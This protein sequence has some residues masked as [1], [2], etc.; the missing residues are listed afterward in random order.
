LLIK[1][2][3]ERGMPGSEVQGVCGCG[4]GSRTE[5]LAVSWSTAFRLRQFARGS[6][7][8]LPLAGGLLGALLSSGAIL[9]DQSVHLPAYWIYSPSTAS[10]VLSAIVGAMAALTG[11]VVTVTVLVVQMATGTFSARYLR[12]W[13][14]DR[15]LKLLLAVLVGTLAFSFGLL[16]RIGTNFVPD[17]GVTAAG[18]LVVV[19][20]LL[21]VVF[22]DRFLHRLRPVAVAA[23][24][25]HYVHR[26]FARYA[27]ALAAPDVFSGLFDPA[28]EQPA[29]VVRGA[30]PGAIQAVDARGLARWAREHQCLVVLCHRVGDFVPAGAR[31]IET[32]GGAASGSRAEG[33]L[34]KM[35]VLGAERTI[36]QDPAF[37]IRIMVDIAD[38]ALSPAVNDPTTAV[39]ALDHLSDV[40]RRIGATDLSRSQWAAAGG[41]VRTGLV[42]PARSWEDYLMLGVTEIREYGCTAIQV[43]R[44]MRAMLEELRDE[45]RPEHRPAVEEELVRLEATVARTFADSVDLDRASTGDPQGIGGRWRPPDAR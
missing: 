28:G 22:L 36:E 21:F 35:I 12:L 23:L 24:V 34:R 3:A 10:T 27:A 9:A 14:R 19:S 29:L 18:V 8:V 1:E 41:A 32:Y 20:L 5:V 16:R 42:I 44:R 30:G 26:D 17:L 43:M 13:Y 40:L 2:R 45:V 15:V 6:L 4:C 37:G 39:Q 25:A 11:F 38:K 31:L 7:W 33:R